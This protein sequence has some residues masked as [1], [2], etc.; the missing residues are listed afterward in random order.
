MAELLFNM[1]TMIKQEYRFYKDIERDKGKT[2]ELDC[3]SHGLMI[4]L[5]LVHHCIRRYNKRNKK[6]KMC[7]VIL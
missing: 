3:T 4:A 7:M 1:Q 2:D 5:N 6:N